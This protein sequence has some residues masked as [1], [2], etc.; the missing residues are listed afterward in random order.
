MPDVPDLPDADVRSQRRAGLIRV[1][2]CLLFSLAACGARP[3]PQVQ[4]GQQAHTFERGR[5][6]LN[7]LLFLPEGY[8]QDPNERWPLLLFLH[9]LGKRGD[10]LEELELLKADGPPMIVEEQPDFPFIVLSPQCPPNSYWEPE[11]DQVDALL[12][13]VLSIYAVDPHRVYLTGLSMGGFG[14]WHYALRDPGRFAALVPIAGG[15]Q[16]GSD[17]VPAD[18]C[19]L[20]DT[21]TWAFH[22]VQDD[23]VP[24]W[25]SGVLVDAPRTSSSRC[26]QKRTTTMHGSGPTPIRRCTSGCWRSGWGRSLAAQ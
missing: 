14:A 16:L 17:A 8:G 22:G 21:P 25:Q 10:S 2:A 13:D 5:S 12:D 3:A 23:V 20:Q 26:T 1:L 9:G 7:Y 4:P 15:H 11:L 19:D 24:A 18:I 6:H